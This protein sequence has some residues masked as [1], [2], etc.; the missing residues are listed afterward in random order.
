MVVAIVM[1]DAIKAGNI[2]LQAEQRRHAIGL[3]ACWPGGG[4][5]K[6]GGVAWCRV[7]TSLTW[8]LQMITF[9]TSELATRLHRTPR[10]LSG[11]VLAA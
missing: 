7:D 10:Y 3:E 2:E 5:A 8:Q 4:G 6:R 9:R 1:L 11:K